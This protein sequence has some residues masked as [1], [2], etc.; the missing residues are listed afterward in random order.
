MEPVGPSTSRDVQMLIG[1]AYPHGQSPPSTNRGAD[2]DCCSLLTIGVSQALGPRMLAVESRSCKILLEL[3]MGT[4]RVALQ[5][6]LEC[7]C[8]QKVVGVEIEGHR[9]AAALAAVGR[10]AEYDPAR[11]RLESSQSHGFR[12]TVLHDG[13]RRLEIWYGDLFAMPKEEVLAADSIIAQVNF[14]SSQHEQMQALLSC[15]KD[16]CRLLSGKDLSAVW[17]LDAAC[18]WHACKED[19]EGVENMTWVPGGYKPFVFEANSSIPPSIF[20]SERKS[21]DDR[22]CHNCKDTEC[23]LLGTMLLILGL[24]AFLPLIGAGVLALPG[25]WAP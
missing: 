25:A 18:C 19:K 14:E 9:F 24:S 15:A 10:L 1:I 12:S 8:L 13:Q 22:T 16:G 5:S 2:E 21:S 11:F 7:K 4:G 17:R 3:G 20:K 6:F 23:L